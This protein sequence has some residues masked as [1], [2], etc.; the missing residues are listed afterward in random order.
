MAI[1]NRQEL[2]E[3]CLRQLGGG[4]V[5]IEVT[6]DQLDD[7]VEL[8]MEF[9]RDY[10]FDGCER[11]FLIIPITATVLTVAAT[12]G[13]IVGE[14]LIGSTSDSRAHV[15]G[16]DG[17]TITISRQVGSAR[18]VANETLTGATS[19]T[20]TTITSIKLGMLDKK[21]FE[22]D[23][24]VMGVTKILSLTNTLASS[25]LVS[26]QY[27]FMAS[28]IQ[29]V[30]GGQTQYLYGMMNYMGH[31]DFVLRKEKD[32]RFNRRMGKL[33]LDI[34]WDAD[35]AVGDK[36]VADI[37]RYVDD[38]LYSKVLND[39]WLKRYTTAVIKKQWGTNTKK[40]GNMTLPGGLTFNGQ[41][42]Y[43]EAVEEIKALEDEARLES[44]PLNFMVG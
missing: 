21:Y 39:M 11:D 5:D 37:Y 23:E 29:N 30:M 12:A 41:Q 18:F 40:Y 43:D 3:F 19:T 17:N 25:M 7:C 24:T 35:V 6:T 10:H 13:F 28:E 26:P 38:D 14:V 32:F 22:P 36:L 15:M 34:D 8:A 4:I 20:V 33:F 42:T 1:Q 27:Q 44:A 16:I 31:L 9:Y 2:A